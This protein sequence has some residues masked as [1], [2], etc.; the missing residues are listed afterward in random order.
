M[1][2]LQDFL[3]K[4]SLDMKTFDRYGYTDHY[5]YARTQEAIPPNAEHYYFEMKTL[6]SPSEK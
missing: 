2:A 5:C 3:S 4:I 1:A 6:R